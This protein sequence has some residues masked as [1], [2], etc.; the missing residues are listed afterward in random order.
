MPLPF[1]HG[2]VGAS[3]FALF[4]PKLSLVR[5][6]KIFLAALFFSVAPDFDFFFVWVLGLGEHWHRGFTHSVLFAASITI[7]M[8]LLKGFSHARTILALGSALLSHALLDSLTT[9]HGGGAQLLFP[10]SDVRFGAGFNRFF[11]SESEFVLSVLV[12]QS[13][14]ELL[15]FTPIFL[16]VL[17]AK[18]YLAPCA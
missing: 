14:V 2:L 11:T 1:A 5:D 18:K 9:A 12:K 3:V 8:L 16:A 15:I 7:L 4:L 10:F 13:L 17:V 6:W